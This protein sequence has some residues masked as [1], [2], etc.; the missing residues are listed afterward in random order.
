MHVVHLLDL[1]G[2]I[3]SGGAHNTTQY[4]KSLKENRYHQEDSNNRNLSR[5]DESQ[6]VPALLDGGCVKK[7]A[8]DLLFENKKV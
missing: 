2:K 7:Q 1:H 6:L 5:W 4:S 3:L 8:R